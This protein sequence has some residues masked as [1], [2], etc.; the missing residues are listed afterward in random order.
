M[1]LPN[2]I[3]EEKLL[4]LRL[5]LVLLVHINNLLHLQ[6]RAHKDPRSVVDVLGH[7]FEHALHLAVHSLSASCR[8]RQQSFQHQVFYDR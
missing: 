6:F 5:F 1:L 3:A 7:D 8:S 2:K 4:E